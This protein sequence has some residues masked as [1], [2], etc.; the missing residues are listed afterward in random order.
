MKWASLVQHGK[1]KC[2][3]YLVKTLFNYLVKNGKLKNKYKPS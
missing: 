1:V 2:Q 3:H